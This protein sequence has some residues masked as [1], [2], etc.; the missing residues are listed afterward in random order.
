MSLW[1]HQSKKRIP[2]SIY[3]IKDSFSGSALR[4]DDDIR[5]DDATVPI[6]RRSNLE[7][8]G[9]ASELLIKTSPESPPAWMPF[10]TA[11]HP[12]SE[13]A[14]LSHR[15][16]SVALVVDRGKQGR[17]A[18]T[19]GH[20]HTLLEQSAIEQGFGLRCALSLIPE[21][22]LISVGYKQ[23]DHESLFANL[24]ANRRSKFSAFQVD[25]D[26]AILSGAAGRP[27]VAVDEYSFVL[28]RT[29]LQINPRI[30][31][32]PREIT[33]LLKWVADVY[34]QKAYKA[35]YAWVD[36][37][38]YVSDP[39][40]I[41]EL[42]ALL[43]TELDHE[44]VE[45]RGHVW[46]APPD[47]TELETIRTYAIQGGRNRRVEEITL[48]DIRDARKGLELDKLESGKISGL[49]DEGRV[50]ERW[51]VLDWVNWSA[52]YDDQT[53]IL[54]GGQFYLVDRRFE[55]KIDRKLRSLSPLPSDYPDWMD[56]RK[57]QSEQVYNEKLARVIKGSCLDQVRFVKSF[58]GHGELEL[59]DVLRSVGK[60]TELIFVKK[61]T[62]GSGVLSHLFAQGMNSIDTLLS[63]QDFRDEVRKS[64]K[65]PTTVSS[66]IAPS[67]PPSP[68]SLIMCFVVLTA[69]SKTN[70]TSLPFF[71]K[72]TLYRIASWAA[73]RG[74]TIRVGI[75][76]MKGK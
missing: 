32:K 64:K 34:A 73:Q 20:G 37:V 12:A 58:R 67:Q 2:L 41:Q 22:S 55:N 30:A 14:I 33:E 47:F 59:C 17:Y 28:G 49:N 52:K 16:Q 70:I 61:Y 26:L 6:V 53:A 45:S 35:S 60:T 25:T 9:R 74:I 5:Q 40:R 3:R 7:G 27:E 69:G 62:G 36:Q 8:L 4:A 13:P 65:V 44:N 21:D 72:L 31:G 15:S 46:L 43:Q 57:K 24:Q 63:D 50:V 66:M 23:V 1:L 39:A 18:L 11:A 29:A 54:Q 51:S 76:P 75:L 48:Q 19:F 42:R 10:L 71:S 56:R 68:A 38:T